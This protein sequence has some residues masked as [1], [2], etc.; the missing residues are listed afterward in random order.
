MSGEI[1]LTV[2]DNGVGMSDETRSRLFT[3]FFSTKSA[4]GTGL[5]LPVVKKIVEEHGGALRVRSEL[6]RGAEFRIHLPRTVNKA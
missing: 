6:G 4:G 3:R 5:G 2:E 1:V